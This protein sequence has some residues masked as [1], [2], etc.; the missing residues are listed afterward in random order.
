MSRTLTTILLAMLVLASAMGLK[1]IVTAHGNGSSDYGKM[2]MV[3]FRRQH[4]GVTEM[5]KFHRQRPGRTATAKFH[6]LRPGNRPFGDIVTRTK[7]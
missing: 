6:P 5:A 1:T 3:R 2:E 7:A 4:L